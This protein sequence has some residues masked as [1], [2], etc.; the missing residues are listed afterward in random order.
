MALR[1][2]AS[3]LARPGHPTCTT[4]ASAP[5]YHPSPTPPRPARTIGVRVTR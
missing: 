4:A 3:G 5:R 1:K 2:T